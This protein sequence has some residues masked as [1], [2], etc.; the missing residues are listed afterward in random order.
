MSEQPCMTSSRLLLDRE[1]AP[2]VSLAF[3]CA[4]QTSH[5]SETERPVRVLSIYNL[6]AE[7][8]NFSANR[9]K[10]SL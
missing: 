2:K 10:T 5:C 4:I 8:E 9:F 7:P 6:L 1:T 3:G